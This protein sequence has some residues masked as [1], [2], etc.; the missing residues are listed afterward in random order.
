MVNQK[1]F[2]LVELLIVIAIVAILAVVAVPNFRETMQR[3]RMVANTNEFISAIQL[4]RAEAIRRGGQ[5]ILAPDDGTN[6]PS[7]L[8]VYFDADGDNT[9]DAGEEIRVWQQM[10]SGSQITAFASSTEL[11]FDGRGFVSANGTGTKPTDLEESFRLC[12]SRSD[13]TGRNINLLISGS[14]WI[15]DATDCNP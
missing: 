3:N 2:T 8:V 4:A 11:S 10:A 9:L 6:W 1:G 7:G 12:D 14:T 13:E 15:A 5:I